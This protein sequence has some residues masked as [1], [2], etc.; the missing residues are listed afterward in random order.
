MPLFKLRKS[1]GPRD[2]ELSMAGLKMGS[3]VLQ[4][5]GDDPGLIVALA[6]VVGLSGHA[7][8]VGDT[9]SKTEAFQRAAASEGVLIDAKTARPSALPFDDDFFDLLVLKNVL[10]DLRQD[11]RVLCLQQ[12]IRVL[13][14]GGRCLVIDPAIRGGIGSV[15]SKRSMDARY[16]RNGG[17]E[18]ALK[19]EG[20]RGVRVLADSDGLTFV[21]GTKFR[22]GSSATAPS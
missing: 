7:C 18:G 13:R 5:D 21:E 14:P 15:F 3:R 9:E 16:L 10:G 6:S 19:E 17:A 8:A 11:D 4:V 20:F 1:G 2:L 22:G 12:A